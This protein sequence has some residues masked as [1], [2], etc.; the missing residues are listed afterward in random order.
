MKKS[1]NAKCK[2][3]RRAGEKLFLRGER[4]YSSKCAIVKRNYPPGVHGPAGAPRLT[5]YGRQLKEKQKA[6]LIYGLRERQMKNYYL[7]AKKRRGDTAQTLLQLLEMRLDNIVYRLGFAK[8]RKQARQ[9]VSHRHIL[10]NGKIAN[11]PSTQLKTGDLVLVKPKSQTSPSFKDL[12]G[13]LEKQE[14]PDW[15]KLDIKDYSGQVVRLPALEEIKQN[16]DIRTIIEF[17]SR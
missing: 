11:K 10:V 2:L 4:C 16:F 1:E 15:L 8:S 14:M 5:S 17:Y 12:A 7:K 13:L 6:K 9:I 3:C